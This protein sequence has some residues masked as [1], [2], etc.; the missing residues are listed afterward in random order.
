MIYA[1]G[2]TLILS[3]SSG[4]GQTSLLCGAT[5]I[6]GYEITPMMIEL[7]KYGNQIMQPEDLR[8][9]K[10]ISGFLSQAKRID[11]IY[12]PGITTFG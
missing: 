9:R 11:V 12:R 1:R 2:S 4:V 8:S 10:T 6:I 3:D 5:H 7:E